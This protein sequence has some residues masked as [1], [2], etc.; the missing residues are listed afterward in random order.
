MRLALTSRPRFRALVLAGSLLS[1]LIVLAGIAV[2]R[3][4]N[5]TE[6]VL[7]LTD[8]PPGYM[9]QALQE[10]L[11]DEPYCARLTDPE[12]TPPKLSRFVRRYHPKGCVGVYYSRYTVPGQEFAPLT[13]GTGV[14][15]LDSKRAADAGWSVVP[16]LLGRLLDDKL[17]REL[18][19]PVRIG[20]ATRLFH[21]KESDP[22][23]EARTASFLA[24]RSDNT[25]A[26]VLV[27]AT[28]FAEGD[29]I[30]AELAR[31][32][33]AHIS[34]PTPYTGAERFDGD[35]PLDDPALQVP[36]YWLGLNFVPDHGLP[37]N[38]FY[39]AT[40]PE[41]YAPT[42]KS[43]IGLEEG[44]G[45]VLFLRYE[46]FAID[47]W[48]AATWPLY[49]KAPVSRVLTTWHCTEA[50]TVALPSGGTATI[51]GGYRR[52]YKRCPDKAPTAFTAWVEIGGMHVVV[53]APW[54]PTDIF[55]TP[56]D[57]FA[58]MEAIARGLQLRPKPVY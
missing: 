9:N 45:A 30:A 37:S 24:W 26:T 27:V 22:E 52:N 32:Q 38:R 43:S 58:G 31:R 51:Y 53:N 23:E 15:A 13:V 47:S 36:V 54:S 50:R 1:V 4:T 19:A 25:I 10:G 8:L 44:P 49:L 42:G 20:K 48:S 29:R 5:Q 28:S 56:Y 46:N 34:K 39:D 40:A 55:H 35:V 2:A 41:P 57:S 6:M 18:P 3:G 11:E 17:P 21:S 14:L 7:R 16:V 12:D 33:Q